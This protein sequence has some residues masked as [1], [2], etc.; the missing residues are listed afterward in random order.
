MAFTQEDLQALEA[1]IASGCDEVAYGDKRVRY[2]T[3]SQMLQARDLMRKE[4]LGKGRT[5]TRR[6]IQYRPD[7]SDR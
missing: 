2:K 1:A 7:Q 3:L 6:Y 5:T 4:L